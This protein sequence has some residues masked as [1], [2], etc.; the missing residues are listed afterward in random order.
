MSVEIKVKVSRNTYE[1]LEEIARETRTTV[2]ELARELIIEALIE[3][4]YMVVWE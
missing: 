2:E 1:L 4:G 3:H